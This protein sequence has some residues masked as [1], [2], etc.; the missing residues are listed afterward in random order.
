[1]SGKK[2]SKERMREGEYD[3]CFVLATVFSLVVEPFLTFPRGLYGLSNG[4]GV[5]RVVV[6]N[7]VGVL[8]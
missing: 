5:D 6:G 3:S 4:P 2:K 8:K 1:M 7:G